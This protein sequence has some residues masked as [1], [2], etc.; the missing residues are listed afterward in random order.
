MVPGESNDVIATSGASRKIVN[1]RDG[2]I[3]DASHDYTIYKSGTDGKQYVV[4]TGRA[5]APGAA[6]LSEDVLWTAAAT[7]GT[8]AA[9]DLRES[10]PLETVNTGAPCVPTEIQALGRWLY[11]SCGQDGAAG[12][13]DRTARRSVPVEGGDVLLGDGFTVRHAGGELRLTEVHSGAAQTRTL[14]ELPQGKAATDRRV[15]WTVDKYRGHVAYTDA[16]GATHIVA[17]GV[18]TALETARARSVDSNGVWP[19]KNEGWDTRWEFAGPVASWSVEFRNKVTGQLHATVKGGA[20]LR[21]VGVHW[22]GKNASGR[23]VPSGTYT[24]TMRAVP[25]NGLGGDFVGTG[26][27]GVSAG[28]AQR[29]DFGPDG[30]PD[31]FATSDAGF[32]YQ[33]AG[34]ADGTVRQSAEQSGGWNGI[35]AHVAFGDPTDDGCNDVLMRT[36]AGELRRYDGGCEMI[37][38]QSDS[39]YIPLG[40]GWNVHNVI[41]SPGDITGDGLPDLIGRAASTGDIWLYASRADGRLQ[42]GVKI[43]SAWSAYKKVVGVGDLNGDGNGDLL[44]QDGSNELWRLD[45][46]DNGTFRSRVLVFSD[47]GANRDTVIGIGDLSGDGKADLVSR[48]TAGN[49]WRNNGNGAGSFGGSKLLGTNWQSYK[50]I[51]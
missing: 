7:A 3:V 24:W 43:S 17:T 14:A 38:L 50:S 37:S 40:A 11:W 19:R 29:H 20:S 4:E 32:L 51:F 33:R 16:E 31:L 1:G 49:L 25:L 27:L 23:P 28:T 10:K 39:A 47:W 41:T 35:N 6:A 21:G 5:L 9:Y 42:S 44:L 45:G 34:Q 8:L 13:Y 15:N 22:D 48:D 46:R 26:E 2:R 18:A 12:V 30:I 36:T